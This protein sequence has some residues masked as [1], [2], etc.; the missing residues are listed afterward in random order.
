M[1]GSTSTSGWKRGTTSETST[2][3]P[4]GIAKYQSQFGRGY[5][6][7]YGQAQGLMKPVNLMTAP[8]YSKG[9]DP[10]VQNTI[11]K[12]L[13]GIKAEQATRGAQTAQTLG[14][15]GSGNNAALLSVLN[16]QSAISG[17]GA[18]N[19]MY[20]T[21]LEQ[22]RQQ[23]IARQAMIAEVNQARLGSRQ[24]QLGALGQNANLLQTLAQ[25][26]SVAKGEKKTYKKRENIGYKESTN[27]SFI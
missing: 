14:T 4:T 25:M 19:Q 16:R 10:V 8:L 13:Q 9:L 26:A 21:G 12:A 11:S 5:N 18:G 2:T 1:G 6:D 15:A 17:A 27:K 24:A 20:A 23:D 7:I 22:Q 3:T